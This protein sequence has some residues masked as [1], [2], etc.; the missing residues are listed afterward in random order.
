MCRTLH[1]GHKGSS[2]M[3]TKA[4]VEGESKGEGHDSSQIFNFFPKLAPELRNKIWEE[5]CIQAEPRIIDLWLTKDS[6]KKKMKYGS[7]SRAPAI[8]HTSREARGMGLQYY[9]FLFT[10]EIESEDSED[11]ETPRQQRLYVNWEHDII[12]PIPFHLVSLHEDP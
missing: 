3:D 2:K 6:T 5:H 10:K 1:F 9:T 11:V 8:L 12:F 7:N 4:G